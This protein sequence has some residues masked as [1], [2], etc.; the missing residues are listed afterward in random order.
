MK[1]CNLNV[2]PQNSS[3]HRAEKW[4]QMLELSSVLLYR[5]GANNL[6]ADLSPIT[7]GCLCEFNGHRLL[8]MA[9]HVITPDS[10]WRMAIKYIPGEGTELLEVDSLTKLAWVDVNGN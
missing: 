9:G 3:L 4:Q 5:I 1:R 2:L 10:V 8:L 6:P 7:S